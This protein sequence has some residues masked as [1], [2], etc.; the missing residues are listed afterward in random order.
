MVPQIF[1][2]TNPDNL[3]LRPGNRHRHRLTSGTEAQ[4]WHSRSGQ[5]AQ[6]GSHRKTALIP[7]RTSSLAGQESRCMRRAA[8]HGRHQ[9]CL[10]KPA[11]FHPET[12]A[13][14]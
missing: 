4:R 5:W 7:R 1:S 8:R 12:T 9:T 6:S 14:P 2:V 11:T 10:P 13:K 3:T